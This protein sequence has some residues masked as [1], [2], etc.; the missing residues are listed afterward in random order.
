MWRK[1]KAIR[2]VSEVACDAAWKE[3]EQ[4]PRPKIGRITL[5]IGP[6][7]SGPAQANSRAAPK[8]SRPESGPEWVAGRNAVLEAMEAEIPIKAAYVAEAPNGTTASV[9]FSARREPRNGAARG[10]AG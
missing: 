9:T 4:R 7:G 3:R 1:G 8:T 5:L 2:P 6:R 10:H